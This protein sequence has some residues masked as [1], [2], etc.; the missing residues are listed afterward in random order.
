MNEAICRIQVSR[1]RESFI[2]VAAGRIGV[3]GVGP[4]KY[5]LGMRTG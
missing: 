2:G 1:S 5:I 4:D 3:S